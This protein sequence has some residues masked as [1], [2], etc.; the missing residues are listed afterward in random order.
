M[1]EPEKLSEQIA[2]F[3][4]A[5]NPGRELKR[6]QIKKREDLFSQAFALE[7]KLDKARTRYASAEREME[8]LAGAVNEWAVINRKSEARIAELEAELKKRF[9]KEEVLE[10]LK[11]TL[12]LNCLHYSTTS[13]ACLRG[14]NCLTDCPIIKK[15]E[16]G[17]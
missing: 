9:T 2:R 4:L 7:A 14:G 10:T 16:E 1:A 11:L 8:K 13:L 15:L 12:K 5:M 6:E 17:K 3:P